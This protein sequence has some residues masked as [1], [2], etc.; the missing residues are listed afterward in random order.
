MVRINE[1]EKDKGKRSL[2]ANL[3]ASPAMGLKPEDKSMLEFIDFKTCSKD[4]ILTR[5]DGSYMR[6]LQVHTTDMY[7]LD[8]ETQDKYVDTFANFNRVYVLD[9]KI[10][11]L[12]TRVDTSEQQKYWRHIRQK[13][14]RS[15][16]KV[17]Q[18]QKR[19]VNGYLSTV[20]EQEREDDEYQEL[21]F[22]IVIFGENLKTI[23]I[24]TRS[25]LLAEQ[26]MLGLTTLNK[27]QTE[28]VIYHLNNL[29][30]R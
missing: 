15:N 11:A 10:I 1:F 22:Y 17:D 12:S 19:A 18:I 4:G 30:S 8:Y 5:K 2:L 24:N 20:I 28:D 16:N 21:K 26:G 3:R 9:Y 14:E 27:K 6:F 23:K 7:S 25:A 29:N 13:L